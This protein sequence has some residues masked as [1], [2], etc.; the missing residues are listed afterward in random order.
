MPMLLVKLLLGSNSHG[1]HNETQQKII[2]VPRAAVDI[3]KTVVVIHIEIIFFFNSFGGRE[4][5]IE[6]STN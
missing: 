3:E 2:Y 1:G 6:V 5:H 4:E